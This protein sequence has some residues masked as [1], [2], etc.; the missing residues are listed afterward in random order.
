MPDRQ[1]RCLDALVYA[2]SETA[3]S[4]LPFVRSSRPGSLW[5]HEVVVG[6]GPWKLEDAGPAPMARQCS[7]SMFPGIMQHP[8]KLDVT[9]I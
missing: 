8:D 1:G 2:A 3:R 7:R 9:I 6:L 4:T 5:H